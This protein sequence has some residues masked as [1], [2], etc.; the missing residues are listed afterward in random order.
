MKNWYC[1]K[2]EEVFY[3]LLEDAT[4][5]LMDILTLIKCFDPDEILVHGIK[6]I[7]Y[8][9]DLRESINRMTEEESKSNTK[10]MFKKEKHDSDSEGGEGHMVCDCNGFWSK[11]MDRRICIFDYNT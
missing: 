6:G 3:K 8:V 5:S 2:Y 7:T 9:L 10:Q 1:N 11:T 4:L